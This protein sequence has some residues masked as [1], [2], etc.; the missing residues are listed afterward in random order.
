MSNNF[1]SQN[2]KNCGNLQ[3][4]Q[5]RICKS[6]EFYESDHRSQIFILRLKNGF[7]NLQKCSYLCEILKSE[8]LVHWSTLLLPDKFLANLDI[9]VNCWRLAGFILF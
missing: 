9:K 6:F 5:K 3:C 1:N 8:Y 4:L 7:I 2:H